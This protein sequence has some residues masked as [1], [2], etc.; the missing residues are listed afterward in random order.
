MGAEGR[1]PKPYKQTQLRTTFLRVPT[2]DWP[3]IKRGVKT[4]FRS[5]GGNVN[6]MWRVQTPCPVVVYRKAPAGYD[7]LLMVLVETWR[8]KLIEMSPESLANE[9]FATF[10]EF[11]H[12]WMRRERRKF[13]PLAEVSVY[14]LR[15]WTEEDRRMMADMI[16]ERLYGEF[17]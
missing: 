16:L 3:A 11:R 1:G 15:P 8:E 6:P 13:M 2:A 12:H 10:E 14:R 17:L 5:Q 9:G 4:E 7:A